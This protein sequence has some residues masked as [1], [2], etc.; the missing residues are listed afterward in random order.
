MEKKAIDATTLGT[1]SLRRAL[2]GKKLL[3]WKHLVA[4]IANIDLQV[5]S[6]TFFYLLKNSRSFTVCFMYIDMLSK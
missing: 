5:G 4:R 6:D 1:I 3:E 2:V